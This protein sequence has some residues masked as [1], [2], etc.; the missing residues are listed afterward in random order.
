M[1]TIEAELQLP[2][3]SKANYAKLRR[4]V[5]TYK[6]KLLSLDA[7]LKAMIGAHSAFKGAKSAEKAEKRKSIRNVGAESGV[8]GKIIS[9][10][11]SDN[12]NMLKGDSD[13]RALFDD[14]AKFTKFVNNIRKNV[15][16][17]MKRRGYDEA[18]I[19]KLL[20]SLEKG[21]I[22]EV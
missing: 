16:R 18:E 20:E 14:P 13:L 19:S 11:V 9:R 3:L 10:F 12:P 17:M 5:K 2:D 22:Y 15:G 21:A 1:A 8:M 7:D 6:Q 4:A